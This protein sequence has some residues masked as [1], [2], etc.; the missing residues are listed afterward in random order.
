[1]NVMLLRGVCAVSLMTLPAPILAQAVDE[2]ALDALD[3]KGV[4]VVVPQREP[5][6][7]VEL[8]AA[9][10]RI[11]QNPN[12]ADALAD[13]GNAS[14]ALGDANAALNFFT[15]ANVIRPKNGRIVSGLATATVRTE[16][17]FEALRLFDDAVRLG[18]SERSIAADRALAFDLLGNFGR[19]QQDYNLARTAATSD[20]LL[21]RQAISLSLAGQK[22]EADGMLVPLLQRNSVPAWRARAF[23]LAARG[24]FRESTK[25]TQGFM[26]TASAQRMERYLRL[27]PNLTSAQQ[28][29]AIHLGHFPASHNVGRDSDQVRR[30]AGN[31]VPVDLPKSESRLIPTGA[32]LGPKTGTGKLSREDK[33]S[34][35]EREQR[36]KKQAAI[37]VATANIPDAIRLPKTDNSRLGTQTARAK[38]EESNNSAVLVT[39]VTELPAPE[40]AR[41]LVNVAPPVSAES[42]MGPSRSQVAQPV[43]A[44]PVWAP[45]ASGSLPGPAPLP[46][47]ANPSTPSLAGN[48]IPA[49]AESQLDR[50]DAQSIAAATTATLQGPGSNGDP[51]STAGVQ[52]ISRGEA[53]AVPVIP[54]PVA[55]VAH[56]FDLAAIVGAIEIPESEQRPSAIPVDLKKLKALPPKPTSNEA[57]GKSVKSD[58]K[59]GKPALPSYPPRQWVQVA[60]GAESALDFDFKRLTKKN[61]ELFKG[62]SGWTSA[63]GK[64]ARLLVGPFAD[65][66]EAKKWEADFRKAGGNGF[67]WK[68][69]EGTVVTKL[70]VK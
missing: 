64:T 23:M 27:M 65:P 20:D 60:T 50:P 48:V 59:A 69:E 4:E 42:A 34:L 46:N 53:V 6:G 19:A 62:R 47:L 39:K 7:A 35:R 26:E 22:E 67:V 1:M 70:K 52:S 2:S 31:I 25:V 49:S 11:A 21:I 17:P 28:A 56:S 16:N 9:I 14:L 13:A 24:D 54:V 61:P 8:R 40:V 30:V 68:S 44:K 29:A 32:P 66:K 36:T 63:W 15:R 37:K 43:G 41:P 38:I 3:N 12:D 10:R 33:K 18:V 55:S 51:I 57:S 5:A 45:G 58:A